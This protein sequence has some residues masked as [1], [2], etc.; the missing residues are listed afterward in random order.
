MRMVIGHLPGMGAGGRCRD[1]VLASGLGDHLDDTG[2]GFPDVGILNRERFASHQADDFLKASDHP[3]VGG[4]C[5][6][7]A[8]YLSADRQIQTDD[9]V[10]VKTDAFQIEH[11]CDFFPDR[12]IKEGSAA[13]GV[14]VVQALV[15]VDPDADV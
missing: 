15:L 6:P 1:H 8:D 9:P 2:L 7:A 12:H 4:A 3:G 5:C 14:L 11:F 13:L 10:F